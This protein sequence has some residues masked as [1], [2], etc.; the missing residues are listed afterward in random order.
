MINIFHVHK[1][2]TLE[3]NTSR[4]FES[5]SDELPVRVYVNVNQQCEKCGKE[6]IKRYR[7]L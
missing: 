3:K 7:T 4:M 6:I 5:E 2:K 1:W